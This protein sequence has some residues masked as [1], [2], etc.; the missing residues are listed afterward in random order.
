MINGVQ[1][2][3]LNNENKIL[4]A[5]RAEY[6]KIAPN[7]WNFIGGHIEDGE[8]PSEAAFREVKEE[9]NLN[10]NNLKKSDK[11][12]A[13][14]NNAEFIC[15]VFTSHIDKIEDFKL[16]KEHSEYRFIKLIEF[17]EYDIVGFNYEQVVNYLENT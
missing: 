1:V 10:L 16:N 3:I 7:R 9:V 8:S 13:K 2:I 17:K 14:W 11:F 12:I 15:H 4:I 6:K 5:K